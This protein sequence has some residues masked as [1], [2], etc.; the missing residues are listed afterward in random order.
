VRQRRLD[1]L[2]DKAGEGPLTLKERRELQTILDEVNRKTF[3]GL[4]D[5]LMRR[6]DRRARRAAS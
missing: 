6:L 1:Q 3:W 4:A 2:L 5:V